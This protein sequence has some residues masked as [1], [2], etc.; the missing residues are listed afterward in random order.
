MLRWLVYAGVV[1]LVVAWA[2]QAA[3]G[4]LN[5]IGGMGPRA[6]AMGGAYTGV[7][8]D[9]SLF[10]YNPAGM[11]RFDEPYAEVGTDILFA[12]FRY[13][14]PLGERHS[15]PRAWHLLPLLGYVH[16]LTDDVAL[17]LGVYVPYGMGAE[18]EHN[19]QMLG[20]H[21]ESLI[22][23]T[24]ISPALAV[25]LTDSLSLGVSLDIG[26]AQF[27]CQTPFDVAGVYL[28]TLTDSEG[29]GWGAGASV[30]LLWRTERFGLGARFSSDV[31]PD[32][33]GK[34]GI[35][36]G[37][38]KIS[39]R[40][41]TQ[42]HFPERL[43][44]GAS[45]VPADPWLFTLDA[46]W[47]GYSGDM[48]NLTLDFSKLRIHKVKR[49]DWDDNYS[50][51]AGVAYNLDEHWT[52]RAGYTY[53]IAAVPDETV[54]TLTPDASGSNVSVGIECE[55]DTLTVAGY[56]LYGWGERSA[57]GSFNKEEYS[58]DILTFG[59]KTAWRF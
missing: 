4:G 1:C 37:P 58:A 10:Y 34:T 9:V 19:P 11:T 42:C 45:F 31:S 33:H 49:L 47:Y 13:E 5:R 18:F 14:G 41:D 12:R 30:G 2:G 17:G 36:L 46:A 56:V 38:F 43:Q 53:V 22:C 39:D 35:H 40:F 25:E 44:I 24:N 16:P 55:R 57:G 3:A 27:K 48:E 21:T 50:F 54:D 32:V 23:L 26:Y 59:F 7:A 28:P 29:E 51:H 6:G 8:D 20:Y 15:V 52:L